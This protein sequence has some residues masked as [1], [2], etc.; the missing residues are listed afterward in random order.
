M[1]MPIVA[2]LP[3][4]ILLLYKQLYDLGWQ[5][6]NEGGGLGPYQDYLSAC[7]G[8]SAHHAITHIILYNNWGHPR[9]IWS[10]GLKRR[11]EE[12][13]NQPGWNATLVNSPSHMIA[14]TKRLNVH[15][16]QAAVQIQ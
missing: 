16:A 15:L 7:D 3:H 14:Y 2:V 4:E 8:H 1:K 11:F 10:C 12:V 9:S 6:Y 13:I 5:G